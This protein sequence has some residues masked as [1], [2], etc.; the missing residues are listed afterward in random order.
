MHRSK[1]VWGP[2]ADKFNPDHFLPENLKN[3]HAYA[4]IPFSAGPR[5]CIGKYTTY[6]TIFNYY[7]QFFK[8]FNILF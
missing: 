8:T 3:K 4:F 5:N 6:T 1:E 2:D 7:L